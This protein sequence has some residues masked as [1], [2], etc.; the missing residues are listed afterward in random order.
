MSLKHAILGFLQMEP[1]S[2][3]DLK[4]M[5]DAS[6]QFYWPATHSQI[7]RT[8]DRMLKD[9]LVT[10]EVVQQEQNPNKKVYHITDEGRQ[11][12]RDWLATPQELPT[13]RHKFLVQLA[14][15]DQLEDREIVSLLE[16]YMQKIRARLMLYRSQEQQTI[17]SDFAR[18]KR[19]K[20]LWQRILDNGIEMYKR[21]L[22]WAQDTLEGLTNLT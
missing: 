21:E 13:I 11:E 8:L 15:A 22:K 19:E 3:Y 17:I 16:G 9:N 14:W 5:F 18:T 6:V 10:Q 12:M 4:K 1:F 2:G 20:F 7:Y